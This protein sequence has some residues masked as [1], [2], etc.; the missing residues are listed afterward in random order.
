MKT[1]RFFLA[2]VLLLLVVIVGLRMFIETVPV[3][4]IG[5]KQR[6][7]G[8]TGVVQ[9]NFDMGFHLG[10]TGFH[11]WYFLDART[12]FLT[13]GSEGPESSSGEIYPPLEVRTEDNNIINLDMTV[14]YRIIP[15][16][17]YKMVEEAQQEIYRDR[18][19]PVVE[20]ELR[21]HLA[22]LSS[23]EIIIT[24][25]RLEVMKAML[26]RLS[27]AMGEF[28]VRPEHVL[29]RAVSFQPI[30][31]EKLQQK[32]LFEQ[33]R[34]LATAQKLV[35]DQRALTDGLATRIVAAEKNLRGDWDKRLQ[36]VSSDNQVE[37]AGVLAGAEVYAKETRAEADADYQVSIATGSLAVA[38]AEALRNELRNQALDTRGGRI[39]LARQAAENLNFDH[40]TLNSNDPNVPSILDIGGLTRMLIGEESK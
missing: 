40:V 10:I 22:Q 6:L 19:V 30:Y 1:S 32:Q 21:E 26:P 23:E 7:W 24:D 35:E 28:H 16:E 4:K 12:H 2:S 18:L 25:E 31:E 11:K 36:E 29:I 34:L 39:F 27:E 33:K 14:T 37:I 20:K 3:A 5:V 38:R 17:A 15:E 8:G 13:F 9:E